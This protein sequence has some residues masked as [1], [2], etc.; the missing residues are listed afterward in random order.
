M[1]NHATKNYQC[2]I[3]LAV[4]GIENEHTMIK[5]DDIFY[6]DDL[7]MA[8]INFKFVGNNPGHVIV[9]PLKHYE[10]LYDL[11]EKEAMR[12]MK[13]A[14]EVSIALKKSR[15]CDGVMILQNNEPASEQHA[16]HYHMHLFSRF[17][18]GKLHENISNFRVS[19]A[20][21][22]KVFSKAMKEYFKNDKRNMEG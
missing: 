2:P 4:K 15:N 22:R 3:C 1:Y 5:Q 8:L 10:N 11:P 20:K 16:F 19:E 17:E 14:K 7:V 12:I 9:A 21:E 6:R 18:N 13:I